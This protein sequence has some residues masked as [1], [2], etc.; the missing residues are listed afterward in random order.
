LP[1]ERERESVA[2]IHY[3]RLG[4]DNIEKAA[5]IT[6]TVTE[7]YS[8]REI[9]E[10][11]CPSVARRSNRKPNYAAIESVTK[12][13]TPASANQSDQLSKMRSAAASLRRANDPVAGP[14]G[15]RIASQ[16]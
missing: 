9:A 4:C 8:S 12:A 7:G 13:Y 10:Y 1:T 14:R 5:S 3:K 15:R 2:A 16:K 11:V 6:S